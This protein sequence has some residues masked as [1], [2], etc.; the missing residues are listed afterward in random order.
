MGQQLP[1][2][3]GRWAVEPQGPLGGQHY[4][5][6]HLTVQAYPQQQKQLLQAPPSQGS[7]GA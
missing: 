1:A 5:Q 2:A 6:A 7:P 3:G 4:P